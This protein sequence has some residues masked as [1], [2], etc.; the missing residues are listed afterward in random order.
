VGARD[1]VAT[2]FKMKLSEDFYTHL[3]NEAKMFADN[4]GKMTPEAYGAFW[5]KIAKRDLNKSFG[6]YLNR[7][8]SNRVDDSGL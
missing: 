7:K 5:K 2:E 8:R 4:N 1:I 6:Q 3:R